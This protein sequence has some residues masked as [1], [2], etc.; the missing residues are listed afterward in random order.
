MLAAKQP[1][2]QAALKDVHGRVPPWGQVSGFT[3]LTPL[4]AHAFRLNS[5][6]EFVEDQHRL[7]QARPWKLLV[8]EQHQGVD[9]GVGPGNVMVK[10]HEAEKGRTE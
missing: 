3:G 6:Q 10:P 9:D 8:H 2:V 7:R 1:N 4:K 5:Q